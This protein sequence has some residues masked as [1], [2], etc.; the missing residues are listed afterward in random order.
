MNKKSKL[1]GA[2]KDLYPSYLEDMVEEETKKWM[3]LH[4]GECE[5]CRYFAENYK[6]G[7]NIYEVEN[8]DAVNTN[9]N[10]EDE[11]VV[12]RAKIFLAAGMGA[13]VLLAIWTSVWILM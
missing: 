11:K 2:F 5:K 13:V 10:E 8:R 1:C 9:M 7:N 6:E 3:E 12:K 4:I